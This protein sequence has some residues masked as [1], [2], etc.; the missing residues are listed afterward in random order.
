MMNNKVKKMDILLND[1]LQE[2]QTSI[3]SKI[4]AKIEDIY[5]NFESLPKHEKQFFAQKLRERHQTQ[6]LKKKTKVYK[7]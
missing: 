3:Q 7:D 6:L 5:D 2:L 1:Q 4:D